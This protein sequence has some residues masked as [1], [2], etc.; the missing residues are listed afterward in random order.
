MHEQG[1]TYNGDAP[2]TGLSQFEVD[3][4]QLGWLVEKERE[5]EQQAQA[6]GARGQTER[7]KH[8]HK[9]SIKRRLREQ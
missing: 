4:L 5:A 1:Y 7:R 9:E 3:K 2:I 8:E 6:A